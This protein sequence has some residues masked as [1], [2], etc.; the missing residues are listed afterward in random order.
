M[1]WMVNTYTKNDKEC[2][3]QMKGSL[4]FEEPPDFPYYQE[5][6][7]I[8]PLSCGKYY[9]FELPTH[10]LSVTNAIYKEIVRIQVFHTAH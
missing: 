3:I 2:Q 8:L 1:L 7:S 4:H 6:Y 5:V 10:L 9:L